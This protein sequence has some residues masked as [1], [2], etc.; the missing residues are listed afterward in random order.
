MDAM[1]VI[2]LESITIT[3]DS[4]DISCKDPFGAVEPGTPVRFTIYVKADGTDVSASLELSGIDFKS[5]VKMAEISR[6]DSTVRLSCEFRP[7]RPGLV[8]YWFLVRAKDKELYAGAL[9]RE[10]GICRTVLHHPRPYQLTVYERSALPP[11]AGEGALYQIFVDRFRKSKDGVPKLKKGSLLHARW[12]DTPVYVRACKDG[13]VKRWTFFGGDI[14]GVTEKLAYLWELGVNAIYLNP[15][16]ESPSNHKYD[17]SDYSRVDPG[18]GDEAALIR[19]CSKAAEWGI[20]VILDGVFSHTGSDS[21]YF[22][23]EGSYEGVGAYQSKDSPYSG[24][25][26]FKDFPED[27]DCWWGFTGLPNVNELDPSYLEFMV[28]GD[29]SIVRKWMRAGIGGWRLDVADELPDE[30]IKRLRKVVKEEDPDAVLIGEVWD[31]ASNKVSYSVRRE[32]LLGHELDSVTGYPVRDAIIQYVTGRC[33]A[34]RF[35]STIMQLMENYPPEQMRFNL[36]ML[37]SHDVL[38]IITALGD[39]PDE[40]SM[41]QEAKEAYA[42]PAHKL[43]L[44]RKRL[45]LASLLQFTLPGTP[46]V[47]YGDEAGMQGYSD[48]YCRGPFPWGREDKALWA[49]N[50]ALGEARA[51]HESIKEGSFEAVA[52]VGM[53]L[54]FMRRSGRD[55]ALIALNPSDEEAILDADVRTLGSGSISFQDLFFGSAYTVSSGGFLKLRLAPLSCQCYTTTLD[56]PPLFAK[57]AIGRRA[58][59]LM[60][61]TS[62][63]SP[64]GIG[65]LGPSARRFVDFLSSS[66]QSLWQ[67]LPMN[68]PSLGDSPYMCYSAMAGNPLIISPELLVEAGLLDAPDLLPLPSFPEEVVDFKA[69]SA[70]KSH[71]FR[72]AYANFKQKGDF[73]GLKAYK[74]ASSHWLRDYSLYMVLKSLHAGSSWQEWPDGAR[75]REE[76]FLNELIGTYGDEAGYHDFLQYVYDAQWNALKAYANSKGVLMVGDMAI[77]VSGDSSDVWAN[78]GMFWLDGDGH[79]KLVSGVPPDSFSAT[80]QLWGHPV[81]RWEEQA[82]DGYGWWKRRMEK[83]FEDF[84]Y[85]RIDHFRGFAGYYAVPGGSLTAEHGRWLKGPGIE[86]FRAM[87]QGRG[88]LPIIAED[89]GVITPDVVDLRQATGFPGMKVLQFMGPAPKRQEGGDSHWVAYTGTHDNETLVQHYRSINGLPQ[90][91]RPANDDEKAYVDRMLGSLY[92]SQY[93]WAIVPLQDL[94]YLGAEARMNMP[95]VAEGNW[96]WRAKEGSMDG[97]LAERLL[98]LMESGSRR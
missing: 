8:W 95:S 56:S 70:Y 28:E 21:V 3:Y 22:N 90:H 97:S 48:P 1:E 23:K 92:D 53:A 33:D 80:G 73:A 58:G 30:F 36:S 64:F 4:R 57:P 9:E 6:Q 37:G 15:V 62:L 40:S 94:L 5:S 45:I 2:R 60:H 17:T 74:E 26:R 82:K 65:D 84:D 61:V 89:L 19:L 34:S 69:V 18:F 10:G 67:V 59:I 46:M 86:L 93:G 7:E 83:A 98:T 20:R 27:Y 32:Y 47:Y 49:W 35:V 85:T 43:E 42:L 63:P 50:K 16:F 77:Y 24:W 55:V 75:L 71:L 96:A 11:W 81:Y 76:G 38:R 87:A 72:M 31:D 79:P 13:S 88:S 14:D 39:A 29:N 91:E 41:S 54:C 78:Q 68:P 66:G 25:Y 12:D 51:V 44:A 52:V